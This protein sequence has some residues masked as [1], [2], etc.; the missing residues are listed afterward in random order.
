MLVI[1][2]RPHATHSANLKLLA[3]LLPELYSLSPITITNP[4]YQNANSLCLSHWIR[5]F[6][7]FMAQLLESLMTTLTDLLSREKLFK[8]H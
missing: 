6:F 1:S 8:Y 4:Q 7:C 2:N 3:Q 5:A